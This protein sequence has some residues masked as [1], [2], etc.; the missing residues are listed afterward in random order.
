MKKYLKQLLLT[1]CALLIGTSVL[2]KL[3][4][5]SD[6]AKAQAAEASAKA[7]WSGKV[8]AYQN[9][10]AQDKVAAHYYQ[11]ASAANKATK[12]AQVMPPCADLGAFIYTPE[13]AV[14]TIEAAGVN[15]PATATTAVSSPGT[16]TSAAA[17]MAIPAAAASVPAAVPV[18]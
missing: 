9:C 14:Q 7:A 6:E 11:S 18:K 10:K 16:P 4:A 17:V 15:S 2:A 5:A 8:S 1:S 12:P 3:P 13:V